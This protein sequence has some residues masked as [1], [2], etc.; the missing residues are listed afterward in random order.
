MLLFGWVNCSLLVLWCMEI[1]MM[2]YRLPFM[3]MPDP[4]CQ[5]N[6]K[7][8]L[9]NAAFV[10]VTIE[11]LVAG[12]CVVRCEAYPIVCSPMSVV[13]NAKTVSG[14]WSAVLK[15]VS[16][17]Q[18][19]QIWRSKPYPLTV[20]SGWLSLS[21][22]SEVRL[23][24]PWHTWRMLA[25]SRFYLESWISQKTIC[26]LGAPLWLIYSMLRFYKADAAFG[27]RV[28]VNEYQ[29]SSVYGWWHTCCKFRVE[30]SSQDVS[31]SLWSWM[32]WFCHK[33]LKV[34][35]KASTDWSM[36]WLI[37]DLKFV[38]LEEKLA[39]LVTSIIVCVWIDFSAPPRS[40]NLGLCTKQLCE[41]VPVV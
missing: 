8:A 1:A 17:S 32:C 37:F 40:H 22:W 4:I 5:S 16:T 20:S 38:A 14:S 9:E 25:I 3:R 19:V 12:R 21:V 39:W 33:F 18:E 7:S 41:F 31:D 6:N 11:E 13:I 30:M 15:P 28:E 2:V 27:K 34:S 24:S 29:I 23:W 35:L 10:K 36:A 26:I